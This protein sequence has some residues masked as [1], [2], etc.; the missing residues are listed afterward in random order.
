MASINIFTLRQG[1][2]VELQWLGHRIHRT[3]NNFNMTKPKGYGGQAAKSK[4]I[5]VLA[6]PK[7]GLPD[8]YTEHAKGC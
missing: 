7:Q 6:W 1:H 8:M 3:K 5:Y 2:V 4:A